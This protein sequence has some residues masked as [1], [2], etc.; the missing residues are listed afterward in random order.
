[1]PQS[2]DILTVVAFGDS[3]T[4][5]RENI[6]K[7]YP[8]SLGDLLK[9]SGM[10]V[11]IINEGIPGSHTGSIK[12]NN[13]HEVLHGMDRFKES[14]LQYHPDWVVICFGI[15][16]S[17]QY[18]GRKDPSII[19]IKQYSN[20]LLYF[21]D[22][23]QKNNG[24][25]ILMTPNPL[26]GEYAGWRCKKLDAYRKATKKLAVVKNT[27]LVDTWELFYNEVKNKT[28]SIDLLL[29]DGM[30][31]NDRG[32]QLMSDALASVIRAQHIDKTKN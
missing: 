2:D 5:P 12:D 29:L 7:V 27:F 17:W 6:E 14:V 25:V 32:H 9:A 24:R 15:N 10:N 4:A 16:D 1:M 19:S 31:P 20:N 8:V 3:T 23:I 30:H 18:K 11:R 21:V 28:N 26:G 22:E 13:F